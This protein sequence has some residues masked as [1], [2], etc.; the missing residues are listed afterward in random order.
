MGCEVAQEKL[1]ARMNKFTAIFFEEVS[2]GNMVDYGTIWARIEQEEK[3]L[4]VDKIG[5]EKSDSDD[6]SSSV[7]ERAEP[8]HACAE[9]FE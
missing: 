7:I 4:P 3:E 1:L 9:S 6:K 5:K 8:N 2:K